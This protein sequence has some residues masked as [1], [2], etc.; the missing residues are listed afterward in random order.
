QEDPT[1]ITRYDEETGQTIIS[2]MGE[3]HLEV[4]VDRLLR[5]FQVGANVGRP[6]VA[7]RET[8]TVPVKVEGRFIKQTGGRGQYGHV[9]IELQPDKRG[10][11][12]EF[13]NGI[14]GGII[15]KQYITP[16]ESGVREAMEGGVLAGYPLVDIKV[17]LYDGSFHEVD[18]SELAF[19]I[20]AAMALKDG[21][22]RAKPILL[23]PVMK[24]EVVTPE[25]FIGD[26]LGDLNSRRGQ[27]AS[28]DSRGNTK[29]IRCF[30][31]LAETFGYATDLR[32]MSQGRATF[33]ME[34]HRYEEL[35]QDLAEQLVVKV[36]GVT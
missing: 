17:T 19:K 5:E 20:A 32:S 14:K 8:I 26:I 24:L 6:R 30:I 13:V 12:F 9:R 34:F 18:S 16:V 25:G 4:I 22:K 3:L 29:I 15:P 10:S 36:G 2:G 27:V 23:E 28:I 35:P 21:V 7:Y 31:P 1:F 33:A 11:G